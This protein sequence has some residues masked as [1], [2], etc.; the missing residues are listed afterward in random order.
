VEWVAFTCA[1]IRPQALATTGLLDQGIFMYFED[2]D[3]CL[4]LRQRGWQVYFVPEVA[5]RHYNRP[6]Y[7]DRTRLR[8]Y[9]QGLG[10]FYRKHY[11]LAPGL[12]MQLL[13]RLQLL[14]RS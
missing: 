1:V 11:G 14:R 13:G 9:Y 7:S 5:V 4:R 10:R 8:N 3:L 12:I 6:S 2:N